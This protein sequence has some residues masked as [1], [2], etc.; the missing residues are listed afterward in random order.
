MLDNS[1]KTGSSSYMYDLE[2]S[3]MF[4]NKPEP[5]VVENIS[6]FIYFKNNNDPLSSATVVNLHYIFILSLLII[7]IFDLKKI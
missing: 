2:I 4:L 7:I 1:T 5:S 6:V 3:Q